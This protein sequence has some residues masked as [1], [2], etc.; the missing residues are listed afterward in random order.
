MIKLVLRFIICLWCL[1]LPMIL[2]AQVPQAVNFQAVARDTRGVAMA[3]TNMLVRFSILDGSSSGQ[4]VYQEIRTVTT[5]GFGSFAFQIGQNP[6]FVTVGSFAEV[7]WAGSAKYFKVDYDPTC[8]YNWSYSMNASALVSVPYAFVADA[9][10][11]IDVANVK[12]GDALIYNAKNQKFEAQKVQL[13]SI[14]WERI[15]HRPNVATQESVDNLAAELQ[16]RIAEMERSLAMLRTCGTLT[17][18]DYD[19]NVYNVV[20]IGGMC[21]LRENLRSTHYA[22]GTP[23][24]DGGKQMS[25]TDGYFYQYNQSADGTDVYGLLYNWT[26]AM[27]GAESESAQGICP[28]G[29]HLPSVAEWNRLA[30]TLGGATVAGGKLKATGTD[31][32]TS[33]NTAA[34]NASGFSALPAG[35][36]KNGQF[37][38]RGTDGCFWTSSADG[39]GTASYRQLLSASGNL[40]DFSYSRSNAHSVRCVK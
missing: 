28:D 39:A 29:W 25:E 1:L 14:E 40:F 9:V 8:K 27:H 18:T 16:G 3:N 26:A 20:E 5:N 22:D 33:P 7:D 10:T 37:G 2:C 36:L 12:D 30:D 11:Y 31:L 21:W 24:T 13:D 15:Q 23:L 34:D 19:G 38:G 17:V 35:Y 6:D 4:T 32:W